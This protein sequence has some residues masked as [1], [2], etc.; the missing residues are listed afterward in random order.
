[1]EKYEMKKP[2]NGRQENLEL[3]LDTI[4]DIEEVEIIETGN[5]CTCTS[6]VEPETK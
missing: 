4:E 3:K 1:M 2:Q 6:T 5:F